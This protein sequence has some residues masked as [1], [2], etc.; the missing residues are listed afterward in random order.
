MKAVWIG[1]SIL[2][3]ALIFSSHACAQPAFNGKN[4]YLDHCASCHGTDGKGDGPVAKV[5]SRTPTDLTKLSEVNNGVF[6]SERLYEVID[7]RRE[8]WAHGTREMPVWGLSARVSP[9]LTRARIRA[10]V[11]YLATLQGK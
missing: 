8:M 10:V 2:L 7:G 9:A 1:S 6:P 11:D 4:Q 5:L 3:P